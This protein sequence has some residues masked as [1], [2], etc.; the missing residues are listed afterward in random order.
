MADTIPTSVIIQCSTVF[1]F[2]NHRQS[3]KSLLGGFPEKFKHASVAPL[4]KNHSVDKSAV[5]NY[6]PVSHLNFVSNVLERLFLAKLLTVPRHNHSLDSHAFRISAPTTWNS[7]PQNFY[8]CSSSASFWNHLKT[9][10]FSSAFSALW[11]LIHMCLDS[12]L[13]FINHLLTYLLN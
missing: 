9:H 10:Y 4:L 2:W 8:D 3:C 6:R 7:L 12:N 11:R 1:F 13:T 5:S